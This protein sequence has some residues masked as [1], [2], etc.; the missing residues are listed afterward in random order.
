MKR[1]LV[2]MLCVAL[3][4]C[5]GVTFQGALL[6]ANAVTVS[7]L[8]TFV[9]FTAL[10]DGN[11]SVV[12]VT[13]VTLVQSGL[14][15]TLAFCGNHDGTFLLSQNMQVSFVPATICGNIVAVVRL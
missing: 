11:G 13:V 8:V 14:P 6:P 5:G 10:S 9:Q 1:V 12:I 2:L 15:Q 3:A 7:G 4:G